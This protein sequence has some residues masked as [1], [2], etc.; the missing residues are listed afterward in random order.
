MSTF[1]KMDTC[2][3]ASASIK[4]GWLAAYGCSA[5]A[6]PGRQA[7]QGL[8]GVEVAT[9][10]YNQPTRLKRQYIKLQVQAISASAAG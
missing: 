3:E 1:E 6:Q 9:T 8:L 7:R 2:I 4:R 5:L 10:R